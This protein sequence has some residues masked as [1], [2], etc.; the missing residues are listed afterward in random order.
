MTLSSK[1]SFFSRIIGGKT[2]GGRQ[3]ALFNNPLGAKHRRDIS[4]LYI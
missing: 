2:T 1:E 4:R 3:D